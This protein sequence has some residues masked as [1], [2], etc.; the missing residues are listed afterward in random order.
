MQKK[1]YSLS[2]ILFFSVSGYAYDAGFEWESVN[3]PIH[4]EY[5]PAM[6]QAY[7]KENNYSNNHYQTKKDIR[8]NTSY[9]NDQQQVSYNQT[10]KDQVNHYQATD[11]QRNNNQIAQRNDNR[12]R[13]WTN[14]SNNNPNY[15]TEGSPRSN[16]RW[17]KDSNA[18]KAYL[19]GDRDYR[20]NPDSRDY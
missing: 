9:Y 5:Y 1:L 15:S 14:S 16:P 7:S 13:D 10:N 4:E 2:M 17:Y 11:Y 3:H 12:N 20:R 19:R 18:R 6:N 8:N